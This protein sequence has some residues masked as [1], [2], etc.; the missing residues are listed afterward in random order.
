MVS[1]DNIR[2][3][4]RKKKL[5]ATWKTKEWKDAVKAFTKGKCC[6]WCGSVE[7]ITAHHPYYTSTDDIYL[8]LYLSGAMVLCNRCHFSLHHGMVLCPRCKSKYMRVGSTICYSCYLDSNPEIRERIAAR[9]EEVKR[10]KRELAKSVRQKYK[11]SHDK[12]SH[13][14]KRKR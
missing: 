13:P 7:K 8:D 12:D 10:I 9:K 3:S 4:N 11:E 6:E 5:R 1:P 2:I 14:T